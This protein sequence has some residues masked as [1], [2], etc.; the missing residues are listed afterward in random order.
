MARQLCL[1]S[2]FNPPSQKALRRKAEGLEPGPRRIWEAW[3]EGESV[4]Y[5]KDRFECSRREYYRWLVGFM[6]VMGV[7]PQIVSNSAILD[8]REALRSGMLTAKESD[9][10]KVL[11]ES[12]SEKAK[13]EAWALERM[14]TTR[15]KGVLAIARGMDILGGNHE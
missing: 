3:V 1:D 7:D 15:A 13:D 4:L 6:E 14:A 2:V 9:R 10:L 12:N 11:K 5:D 8:L